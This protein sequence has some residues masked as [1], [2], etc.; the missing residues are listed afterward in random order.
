MVNAVLTLWSGRWSTSSPWVAPGSCR[1]CPARWAS[2]ASCSG[3]GTCSLGS[4]PSGWWQVWTPSTP[5]PIPPSCSPGVRH[6]VCP[7]SGTGGCCL[8]V[9]PHW[10]VRGRWCC[11]S[12][13]PSVCR[14]PPPYGGATC[15]IATDKIHQIPT[16]Q[17]FTRTRKSRNVDEC[18]NYSGS[19]TKKIYPL[20]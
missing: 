5:S 10:A 7:G 12:A 6:T 11:G 2:S 8:W 3:R 17:K 9:V 14:P 20:C 16:G 18:I 19:G 1:P 4:C 15:Q 13:A